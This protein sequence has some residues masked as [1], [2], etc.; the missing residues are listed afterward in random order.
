MPSSCHVCFSGTKDFCGF[1]LGHGW[2]SRWSTHPNSSWGWHNPS[3]KN[4]GWSNTPLYI[5]VTHLCIT[6]WLFNI[7]MGFLWPIEIDG[8]PFLI[9][10]WFSMA[11]LVITKWYI[12]TTCVGVSVTGAFFYS[13]SPIFFLLLHG[14]PCSFHI[15]GVAQICDGRWH[16]LRWANSRLLYKKQCFAPQTAVI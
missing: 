14:V 7:A 8:L 10:W 2:C 11:M 6:L 4:W 16:G 1:R 3:G 5:H 12:N 15:T 9:A 13:I